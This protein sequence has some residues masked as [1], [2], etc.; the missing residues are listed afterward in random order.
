MPLTFIPPSAL[1]GTQ[2]PDEQTSPQNS[3][4]WI[5]D[6]MRTVEMSPLP[7]ARKAKVW[8][9]IVGSLGDAI[10][11][12][13]RI[14]AGGLP[15]QGPYAQAQQARQMEFQ[16]QSMAAE[17][18]N[19][20]L[21]NRL[22]ITGAEEKARQARPG[23]GPNLQL[24]QWQGMDEQGRPTFTPVIFNPVTGQTFDAADPRQKFVAPGKG[25][26]I[27]EENG[28]RKTVN[29]VRDPVSGRITG[30]EEIGK[31]PFAPSV[32]PGVEIDP[33]TGEPRPGFFRIPKGP[34]A[35]ERVP[36]TGGDVV[37]LP[38][39]GA[40]QGVASQ[41][42]A[43]KGID[44]LKSVWQ[45][46]NPL[47][48][49][50]AAY[51]GAVQTG[52]EYVPGLT[53]T[54]TNEED[55]AVQSEYKAAMENSLL[56]YVNALSGKQYTIKELQKFSNLFP[57]IYDPEETVNVKIQLLTESIMRD[58]SEAEQIFPGVGG[59]SRKNQKPL[60]G[61]FVGKSMTQQQFNSLKPSEQKRWKDGGGTVR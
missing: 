40:A 13:A 24:S 36:T 59:G 56:R 7:Q 27:I 26:A 34:G 41:R 11:T 42:A 50:P 52:L 18:S 6:L 3:A 2:P 12:M 33:L 48:K 25:Q 39:A 9:N 22:R 55:Y 47:A 60:G 17:K 23:A 21:R 53:R 57:R 61:A 45:K 20:D 38:P 4:A 29:V 43:M 44:A 10:M 54:L 30:I 49:G 14:K 37:P 8:Q 19:R 16:K 46:Y 15:E 31:T 51:Q 35:M 5:E 28:V 32:Q 1:S 58:V